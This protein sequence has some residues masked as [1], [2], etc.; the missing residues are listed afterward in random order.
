MSASDI[1]AKIAMMTLFVIAIETLLHR[2]KLPLSPSS[3]DFIAGA[4]GVA[5]GEIFFNYSWKSRKDK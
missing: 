1:I 3:I 4:F 2:A 5:L